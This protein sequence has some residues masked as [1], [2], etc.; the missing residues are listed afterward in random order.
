MSTPQVTITT[1]GIDTAL[2]AIEA[3][4]G[5]GIR[6]AVGVAVAELAVIPAVQP[7]PDASG[8]KM[9]FKTAKQRRYI[10]RKIRLEEMKLPYKRTYRLLQ[11]WRFQGSDTGA[12]VTNTAPH[13]EL[14][15]G[16]QQA[17]YHKGTWKTVL[18][19]AR[20]VESTTAARVGEAA[21]ALYIT[22]LGIG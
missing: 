5:P 4:Q 7:Y 21:A 17:D 13:A 9:E 18:E 2:R 20:D 15:V 8:K 16:E 6:R 14:V 22:R 10:M 1:T 19:Y 12:T 11:G 3:V